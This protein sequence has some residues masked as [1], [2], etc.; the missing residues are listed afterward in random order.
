MPAAGM[1][2]TITHLA[3]M[4]TWVRLDIGQQHQ[5]RSNF[6]ERSRLDSTTSSYFQCLFTA[7]RVGA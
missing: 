7:L 4:S 5:R 2:L 1:L 6:R 3:Q